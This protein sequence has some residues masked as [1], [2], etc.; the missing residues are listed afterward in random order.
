[1]SLSSAKF[2]LDSEEVHDLFN[3]LE[4]DLALF[5]ALLDQ[6]PKGSANLLENDT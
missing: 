6:F 3:F 5:E 2:F 4:E 1:M